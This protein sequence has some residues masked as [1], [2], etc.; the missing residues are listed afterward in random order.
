MDNANRLADP[1]NLYIPDFTGN[2]KKS[3]NNN[4]IRQVAAILIIGWKL[5]I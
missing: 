3:Q 4:F 1:E 2:L 5:K